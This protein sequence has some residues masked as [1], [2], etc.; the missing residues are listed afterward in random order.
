MPA[1]R[2]RG[3]K[4]AHN[5]RIKKRNINFKNMERAYEKV[6]TEVMKKQLENLN[7]KENGT[8]ESKETSAD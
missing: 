3:G 8:S 7:L 6:F 5:K 4:K 1:S 2:K